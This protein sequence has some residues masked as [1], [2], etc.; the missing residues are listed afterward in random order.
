MQPFIQVL[1]YGE[2]IIM[3]ILHS[4]DIK[5]VKQHVTGQTVPPILE[6]TRGDVFGKQEA[7]FANFLSLFS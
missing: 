2:M 5:A 1:I 6:F 3:L 7:L 4:Q